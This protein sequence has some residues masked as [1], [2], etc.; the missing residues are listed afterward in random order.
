MIKK[1]FLTLL[2]LVVLYSTSKAREIE[3]NVIILMDFSN[4]YFVEERRSAIKRNIKKIAKAIASKKSGP[5]KP[6][7]VQVLGIHDASQTSGQICPSYTILRKKLISKKD[8]EEDVYA[9]PKAKQF[10]T[11]MTTACL[12]D[13]MSQK[14]RNA[15]DIQGAISLAY[16]LGE[17]QTDNQKYIVIFSDMFEYRHEDLP[18]TKAD[19]TDYKILVVCSSNLNQE[20]KNN[21]NFCMNTETQW[22]STFKK[23]GASEVLYTIET[24]DWDKKA[25]VDFFDN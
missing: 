12:N 21:I 8:K 13:I 22:A 18:V 15:T 3:S 6:T 16:Q 23:M 7:L 25:A 1:C 17:S 19:L 11:Y 9:S 2:L 24:G 14:A 5:E 20:N 4:S 10:K